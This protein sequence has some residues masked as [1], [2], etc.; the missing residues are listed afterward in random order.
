MY[1]DV[2]QHRDDLMQLEESATNTKISGAQ[3]EKWQFNV[4]ST[5]SEHTSTAEE[6]QPQSDLRRAIV[7]T[8]VPD[9]MDKLN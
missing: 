3:G 2:E 4:Q 5:Y 8:P 9:G 7:E 1:L 6:I